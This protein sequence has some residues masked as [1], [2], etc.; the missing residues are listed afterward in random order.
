MRTIV[1]I[2]ETE[3]YDTKQIVSF[4]TEDQNTVIVKHSAE[5]GLREIR[6]GNYSHLV[7]LIDTPSICKDAAQVFS[8]VEETNDLIDRTPVIIVTD[9]VHLDDDLEYLGNDA[10]D[11]V[12]KPVR[13]KLLLRRVYNILEAYQSVSFS[14]FANM[15]R[16]LPANVY[17]KDAQGRYVFSSQTWRHLDTGNDP[18][19]TI[20]GK[21]DLEVRFD[22]KNARIAMESD[23]RMI[24]SGKGSSYIIQESEDGIVEYLQLIKEPL[25]SPSGKVMGII[26]LINNVT[27]QEL[28]KQELEKQ[29]VTDALTGVNNRVCFEKRIR[30]GFKKEEYPVSFIT[31][32]CDNLKIINDT[33]GHIA[34]DRW[35]CTGAGLLKEGIG[36]KGVLYRTGGDEFVAILTGTDAK[37]SEERIHRIQENASAIELY[38]KSFRISIGYAILHSEEEDLMKCLKL[39]DENMYEDKMKNK[40]QRNTEGRG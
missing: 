13:K 38:G 6:E 8:Y 4:L 22:K 11:M 2:C 29:S 28:M 14:D 17:L 24:E 16:A 9:E 12:I 10:M 32:D 39:S 36:E 30:K 1:Y 25:F 18:N 21:T 31:G 35:I 15:L 40:N 5:E 26:A 23:R 33:K 37:E 19:W 3:T 27:D 20:R 7:I 34:G